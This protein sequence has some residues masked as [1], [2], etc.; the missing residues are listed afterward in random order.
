MAG[1]FVV[2][3]GQWGLPGGH[4]IKI[5]GVCSLQSVP[6]SGHSG[7]TCCVK[8]N[9]DSKKYSRDVPSTEVYLGSR[10]DVISAKT[11]NVRDDLPLAVDA[12]A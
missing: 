12:I 9:A 5:T 3:A 1:D 6:N 7:Y 2:L 8:Q 11:G 10:Y 4:P